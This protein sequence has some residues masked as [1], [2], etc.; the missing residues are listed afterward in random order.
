MEELNNLEH[1]E[2]MVNNSDF[3]MRSEDFNYLL[4]IET[5]KPETWSIAGADERLSALND[6][7]GRM[8]EIM[9]REPHEVTITTLDLSEGRFADLID[10]KILVNDNQL[11]NP[12]NHSAIVDGVINAGRKAYFEEA[13]LQEMYKTPE[14]HVLFDSVSSSP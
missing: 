12:E 3:S 11:A 6:L 13:G 1:L 8:A 14:I 10:Q 7:E 4:G 9:N 2:S 5:L